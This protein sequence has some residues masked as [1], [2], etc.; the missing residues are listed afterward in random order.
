[1]R[2]KQLIGS[3]CYALVF[4]LYASILEARRH[5]MRRAKA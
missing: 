5:E 4:L 1:M 2:L 3:V